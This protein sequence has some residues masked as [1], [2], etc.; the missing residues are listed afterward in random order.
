M[1]NSKKKVVIID[2]QLGNLF[3]VKQ[4][5]DT[6]GINAEISSNKEDVLN[7]DALILP[8]VGAFIEAM[9]NLRKFGLDT[10]IQEKVNSGTPIFGICLGL[11]LLFTES[12][13]F[14]AGKGLDLISGVIK[15]FPEKLEGKNIKVPH[16]AWNTIYKLQQDWDHSALSQIEENDFMYFIHSYYVKPT[17][18]SCIL[19]NTNYDGIEFCSSIL[20]SNIFATQFHPEKSASKGISIYKNWALINNLL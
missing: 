9:I 6:I 3:S 8:G 12:E 10:A 1:D 11:Q 5:C 2:Y 19:T 4:A 13:E 17:H 14:G 16:I 15:R 18:D 20:K 7:A